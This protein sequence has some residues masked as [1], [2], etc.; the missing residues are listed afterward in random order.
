M[1][2]KGM[3]IVVK[4][5]IK[6][7]RISCAMGLAAVSLL[8]NASALKIVLD[9]GHGGKSSG[10]VRTYDDE[11]IL[12]KDLNY[13]IALA[14]KKSM[15]DYVTKDGDQVEVRLTRDDDPKKNPSLSERVGLGARIGASAV[16]SLH[17]N[18]SGNED[19]HG[20]MVLATN[21]HYNGL[22]DIEENL[23][24]CFLDELSK[25]GLKIPA[26]ASGTAADGSEISINK[27]ILRR[28]SNDGTVYEDGGTTDWYGIVR[29][30]V[31]KKV[32][33]IIV[34]HAYLS[35][36]DDY[37]NFLSSDEKLGELAD[38]DVRA[39]VKCFDLVKKLN[40]KNSAQFCEDSSATT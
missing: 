13:K 27:G 1:N 28:L 9:P 16:I 3:K 14:I 15:N 23:A 22:Y 4:N 17:I 2:Q 20:T 37:Q 11:Q 40:I 6:K 39:L 8:S 35:N 25:L 31:L 5:A 32:P 7:I 18:S 21:S 29:Q 33:A 12:E 19:K 34:E 38:A 30:G 10:C 24:L 26:D 36:G